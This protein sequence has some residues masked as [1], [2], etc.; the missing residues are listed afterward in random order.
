MTAELEDYRRALFAAATAGLAAMLILPLMLGFHVDL[1]SFLPI[2]VLAALPA[3]ALP[4]ASWRGLHAIRPALEATS[5]GLLLTLPVLVLS[6]AAMR[7]SMPLADPLLA[8]MDAAIGFDWAQ[9]THW[10]DRSPTASLILG[11]S[12]SSFSFQLLL[13]PSLLCIARLPARAYQLVI[14]YVI[15][16]T[17]SAAIAVFFPSVGAYVTYG[18]DPAS[19]DNISGKFGHFFLDS[20]HAVRS[21]GAFVLRIDNAAGIV[22]FPSV[23]VGIAALCVWATWPSRWLRIPFLMLNLA[24]T[25]SAITHGAHYLVDIAGGLLV[26]L[27]T[28]PL[29]HRLARAMGPRGPAATIPWSETEC[30][31]AYDPVV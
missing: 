24:M 17:L 27:A 29:V 26:A 28:I 4:Y 14:A 21:D 8:R 7:F 13:L 1:G 23:H 18:L 6:F 2:Y 19:L 22:T 25:V 10:I 30:A 11:L 9:F 3:V 20:F 12:Y 15:L 31:P 5:L 16:C